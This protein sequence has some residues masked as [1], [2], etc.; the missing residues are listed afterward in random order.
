MNNDQMISKF[1][2][3]KNPQILDAQKNLKINPKKTVEIS[4]N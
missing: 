4:L 3:K 2:E 1:Y